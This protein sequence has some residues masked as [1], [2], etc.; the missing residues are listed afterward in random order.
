MNRK[1]MTQQ[2]CEAA[3]ATLYRRSRYVLVL[4]HGAISIEFRAYCYIIEAFKSY[5]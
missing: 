4:Q 1:P 3:L 2:K 5:I